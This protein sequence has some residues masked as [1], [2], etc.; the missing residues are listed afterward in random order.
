M[1]ESMQP[2]LWL[3]TAQGCARCKIVRS[4][5]EKKQLSFQEIDFREKEGQTFR[6]FYKENRAQVFRG[7]KGVEFP[8]LFDGKVVRQG[9]GP[10]LAGLQAGD[11]LNRN[12]TQSRLSAGWLSGIDLSG[13]PAASGED[14]LAILFWMKAQGLKVEIRSNGSAP[15]VLEQIRDKGLGHRLILEIPGPPA[16]LEAMEQ[17]GLNEADLSQSLGLAPGFPEYRLV[18]IIRPVRRIIDGEKAFDCLT[19]EEIRETARFIESATQSKTHPYFLLPWE[20]PQ[21][22]ETGPLTGPAMFKYRTAAR[23]YQVKTEI[24]KPAA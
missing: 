2:R 24:G 6:R 19:P 20:G 4:F 5:M 14:L 22:P 3:F 9:V 12:I 11:A 10:I 23:R 16:L 13:L 21:T 7:E 15:K 8:I 18:T 17:A 1:S